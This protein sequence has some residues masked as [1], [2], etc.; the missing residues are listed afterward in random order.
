M[1]KKRVN[2]EKVK[3]KSPYR[4]MQEMEQGMK[5]DFTKEVGKG[6]G[7]FMKKLKDAKG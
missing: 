3:V 2:I 4:A 7:E 5:D 1:I 6:L